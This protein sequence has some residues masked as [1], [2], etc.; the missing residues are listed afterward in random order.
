MIEPADPIIQQALAGVF[1]SGKLF[2]KVNP[3][4][5]AHEKISVSDLLRA[6]P[7]SHNNVARVREAFP[8]PELRYESEVMKAEAAGA[9]KRAARKA[10]VRFAVDDED[11][12]EPIDDDAATVDDELPETETTETKSTKPNKRYSFV[13]HNSRHGV[14]F[15]VYDARSDTNVLFTTAAQAQEHMNDLLYGNR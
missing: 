14:Y 3:D 5:G 1:R 8:F 6:I 15:G 9:G 10:R 12:D 7:L 2:F 11:D 4:T 13:R